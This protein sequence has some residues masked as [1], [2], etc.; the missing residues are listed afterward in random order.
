MDL[1]TAPKYVKDPNVMSYVLTCIL[2]KVLMNIKG[3][4]Y[5]LLVLLQGIAIVYVL[6]CSCAVITTMHVLELLPLIKI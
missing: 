3:I 4:K 1:Y 2:K 5:H 6:L